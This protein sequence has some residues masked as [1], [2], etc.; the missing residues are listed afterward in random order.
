[1]IERNWQTAHSRPVC[2]HAGCHI[3]S[4][5]SSKIPLFFS[6]TIVFCKSDR[7]ERLHRD[8]QEDLSSLVFIEGTT[9]RRPLSSTPPSLT[10]RSSPSGDAPGTS[11]PP[12][13]LDEDLP[14]CIRR[15]EN[16]NLASPPPPPSAR[17]LCIMHLSSRTGV[18]TTIRGEDHP[19]QVSPRESMKQR[20]ERDEEERQREVKGRR[21]SSALVAS[22]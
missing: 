13:V 18:I 3:S 22:D 10:H 1:M 11:P 5:H 4:H 6:V 20:G 16:S 2:L 17:L 7:A 15:P 19:S 8:N 12:P 9:R 14:A 21:T